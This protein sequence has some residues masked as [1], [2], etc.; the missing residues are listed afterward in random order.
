MLT[1][2]L[3]SLCTLVILVAV[4]VSAC[5][6]M[7]LQTQLFHFIDVGVVIPEEEKITKLI[8]QYIWSMDSVQSVCNFKY[9]EQDEA[10]E[11]LQTNEVQAVIELPENFYEDI[12][13]GENTPATIYLPEDASFNVEVFQELFL[14]GVSMVQISEAGVYASLDTARYKETKIKQG[15]IGNFIIAMYI[16]ST[17]NR[18]DIYDL[19]TES[20]FGQMNLYQYYVTSFFSI[21]FLMVGLNFSFLY[22][23]GR[24][25]VE[26]KMSMYGIGV[27]KGS[28]IKILVM[29]GAL[30]SL[31]MIA[32][33]L[34]GIGTGTWQEIGVWM[35]GRVLIWL[36]F[37]CLSVASFFH[38][39]YTVSG[40]G[41]QGTIL[42]LVINIGMILCSGAVLPT[43]FFPKI[44]GEV[45]SYLPI[46]FWNEYSGAML[47][48]EI[49][50]REIL[51]TLGF[52]AAGIAVGGLVRWKDM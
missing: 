16:E 51:T 26:Q 5:S 20:P 42:L 14:D 15:D 6:Y 10:I 1:K 19:Y 25:A 48:G 32:Y 9:L 7:L 22:Q 50:A 8:A 21:I 18:D 30:W 45:G 43:V 35:D 38:A 24:K 3:A 28:V 27:W 17:L 2:S 49:G 40:G 23:S 52:T 37:F 12:D 34:L 44:I 29:T 46:S 11:K 31:G 47:F 4:G 13:T 41:I 39:V 36:F 33:L